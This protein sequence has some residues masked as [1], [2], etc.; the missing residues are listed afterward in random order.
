VQGTRST[1]TKEPPAGTEE[2]PKPTRS[3][4]TSAETGRRSSTRMRS[5]PLRPDSAPTRSHA[6]AAPAPADGWLGQKADDVRAHGAGQRAGA[7][8]RGS[9]ASLPR[10]G[11]S[12]PSKRGVAGAAARTTKGVA[13]AFFPGCVLASRVWPCAGG[14]CSSSSSCPSWPRWRGG[15]GLSS[16]CQPRSFCWGTP[17][18]SDEA[19]SP[20]DPPSPPSRSRRIGRRGWRLRVPPPAAVAV[21][22]RVP[23][24]SG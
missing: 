23:G 16:C 8:A 20:I 17:W 22:S 11:G 6:I 7:E 3:T 14:S 10:S 1:R 12:L 24:P 19:V 13:R 9:A 21:R 4:T 5:P 2:E 18:R 15:F